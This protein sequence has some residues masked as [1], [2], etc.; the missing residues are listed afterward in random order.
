MGINSRDKGARF[1]RQ[2][3]QAFKDAGFESAHRSS[4]FCGN[5]GDAPDVAGLEDIH[6]ECKAYKDTEWNDEW[7]AQAVR[8]HKLGTMPVVIHKTDRHKPKVRMN[9]KDM[10]VLASTY[11]YADDLILAEIDFNDFIEL[12]AHYEQNRYKPEQG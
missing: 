2:I 8:D 1:E 4:Q 11:S 12:Y 9:I 7:Y 10:G 5:T 3:A 6:V